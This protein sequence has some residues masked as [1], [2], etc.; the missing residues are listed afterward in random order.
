[1]LERGRSDADFVSRVN[2]VLAEVDVIQGDA[3]S[4]MAKFDSILQHEPTDLRALNGRGSLSIARSA[5][6]EGREYFE[7]AV[8][9]RPYDDVALS[10]L[11]ICLQRMGRYQDAWSSFSKALEVNISNTRALAGLVESSHPLRRPK[12]T[13]L[14]LRAYLEKHPRDIDFLY[15]LAGACVAQGKLDEALGALDKILFFDP[16]H[17]HAREL[18]EVIRQRLKEAS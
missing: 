17:R 12:E 1:V 6:A 18:G 4:A 5:W 2:L 13:E 9:V 3:E 10:G 7:R 16:A 14:A 15:S 8:R 11:G